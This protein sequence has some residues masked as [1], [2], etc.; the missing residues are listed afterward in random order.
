MRG[1]VRSFVLYFVHFGF[2]AVY[3]DPTDCD[4]VIVSLMP[5]LEL[6]ATSSSVLTANVT[7]SSRVNG[8]FAH[9][10]PRRLGFRSSMNIPTLSASPIYV[11]ASII[12]NASAYVL[13]D[14]VC[15]TVAIPI[16]EKRNLARLL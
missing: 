2:D 11:V 9:T 3:L 5:V 1:F 8:S 12:F 7:A 15:F 4:F 14:P 13:T 16:S 10:S 6:R